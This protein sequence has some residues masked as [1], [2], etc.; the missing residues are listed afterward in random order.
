MAAE[1][2]YLREAGNLLFHLSVHRGAGRLRGRQPVR[3]QGRRDRPRRERLLQ[4]PHAVRRLQARAACSTPSRWSRSAS[5]ST[6]STSSGSPSGRGQG[7]GPQ[8]RLPPDLLADARLGAA[9][10][11]PAGQPPA[12]D[13]RHRGLPDRARL[14]AGHHGARRQRR[15]R[16]PAARPSSCRRTRPSCRS[17]W[18]R[19]PTPSPTQIGLEGLFYPTYLKVDGDPVNVMG[20]LRNPT[21]SLLRP[22]RATWVSTTGCRSR[23][24]CSTRPTRP[25]WSK[26]DGSMFRV[27]LQIGE[28][29]ELPDGAGSV[30][31]D[32]VQRVEPDPDQPHARQARGPRPASCWRCSG[33]WCRCSSG[34]AGSG[35]G[36]RRADDGTEVEVAGLERT[37]GGDLDEVLAG[38]VAALRARRRQ[39]HRDGRTSMSDAGVGGPQPTRRSRPPGWSTSWRCWPTWWSGARCARSRS[40]STRSSPPACATAGGSVAVATDDRARPPAVAERRIAPVRPDRPAAHG[41]ACGLHG[42]ALVA[43]GLAA[44][45]NRVPWGNM[46][47]FTLA[48]TFFVTLIYLVLYRR[49]HLVVARPARRPASCSRCSWWP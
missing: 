1:R 11:R 32:G 44:D 41:L 23:S 18:S 33:C 4:R 22:T 25:R 36:A 42:V 19:R 29:V 28:T 35:C 16:L 12:D 21:L 24:T 10:V 5:P 7:H 20:D 30:T 15:R 17:G 14:R 37:E 45:P 13:R 6:T 38:I 27:D 47:E 9:A 3:L 49:F 8:V 26:P 46:Y 31:F 2:G 39:R 43:R 48:G 40:P 34:R